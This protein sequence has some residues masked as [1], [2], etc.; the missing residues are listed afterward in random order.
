MFESGLK[1]I[2]PSAQIC[3]S[4]SLFRVS[5]VITKPFKYISLIYFQIRL[6]LSLE[7]PIDQCC[8]SWTGIELH[9]KKYNKK[10]AIYKK[11][12]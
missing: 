2:R 6:H 8:D 10:T 12:I 9:I 5:W 7:A 1:Y 11:K 3:K 4:E